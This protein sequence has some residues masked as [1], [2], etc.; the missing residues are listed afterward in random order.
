M[1]KGGSKR[2]WAKFLGATVSVLLLV[3]LGVLVATSNRPHRV[4]RTPDGCIVKLE[5]YTFRSGVVRYYVLDGQQDRTIG[6]KIAN[7]LPQPVTQRLKRILPEPEGYADSDFPN[8]PVL[9]VVFSTQAPGHPGIHEIVSRVIVSDDHG[10]TFDGVLNY[11]G[12]SSMLSLQPF[13]RRGSE[14]YLRPVIMGHDSGVVFTIPNPCPGPHPV[15]KAQPM[16]IRATNSTLQVTLE[17]FVADRVQARTRCALR[18]QEDGRGSTA[19]LPV[20]FEI[21]DATGNHWKPGVDAVQSTNGLFDCSL[22]GALW[23]DEDAW[24]VH[25]EFKPGDKQPGAACAVD[26]WARPQQI[27]GTVLPGEPEGKK[28]GV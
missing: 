27:G 1:P 5:R 20:A 4:L 24:R 21:S 9:S 26:F 11:M 22:F 6:R 8:E 2:S 15:W 23:P 10:Q 17:S 13:P 3:T 28:S 18:V 7:A 12:S 14:L 16:P 25:V 19:W